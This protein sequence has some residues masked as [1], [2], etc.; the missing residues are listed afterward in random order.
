VIPGEGGELHLKRTRHPLLDE[1]LAPLRAEV[2]DEQP[3]RSGQR[4]V[5]PLSFNFPENVR[6]LVISGP[7]AGGKTVVLKTIGLMVMMCYHGIPL[8]VTKG[9]TVPWFE[10]LWFRIGDDQDVSADLSTFSGAMNATAELLRE[11]GAGSLVLYDEL[12]S[13]TDPLEGA[14]LGCALLEELT[15]AG[16]LTVASTHLAAVALAAQTAEL[17]ANASMD[18]D[19]AAGHPTYNLSIG[20]PGRSRG[21]EIA[22]AMGVAAPVIERAKTLLGGQHL[23]IDRWLERLEKLEAE[24]LNARDDAL[25]ERSRAEASRLETEQLRARLEQQLA[26]IPTRLEIDRERLRNRAKKRLDRALEELDAARAEQRHLGRKARQKVREGA[27]DL[28]EPGRPS[29]TPC[30]PPQLE[31]G[32]R[33]R[34]R[35]LGADGVL[36]SLRGSRARV[37]VGNK[38]LWVESGELQALSKPTDETPSQAVRV[39]VEEAAPRELM[40]LGLDAEE[41]LER[42]ERFLDRAHAAGLTFVRI[43]HGHGTGTLRR[44]VLDVARNHPAVTS[45]SHPPQNR[46]GSG[47][48]ELV[49]E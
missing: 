24:A 42:V 44:V 14:A 15:A 13:G 19:E 5:V 31:P 4:S 39:D 49:L 45:F 40:L 28:D 11:A 47:A 25:R 43:V 8:P 9:S 35:T 33:V 17:M 2:L 48:T 32:A 6:T 18:Y 12:G 34:L 38:K 22:T 10:H 41:A 37:T 36:E 27:L 21:L 16:C 23:E 29:P 26:T 30:D 7:N 3:P 1:R 46:G 20:R